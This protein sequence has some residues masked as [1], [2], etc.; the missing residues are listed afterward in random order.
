MTNN[1]G[2]EPW[3]SGQGKRLA[4]DRSWVQ[5]LMPN[6]RVNVSKASNYIEEK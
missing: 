6:N 4:T 3:S 5:I 1:L 2:K